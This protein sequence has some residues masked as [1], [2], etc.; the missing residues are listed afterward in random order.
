MSEFSNRSRV[1]IIANILLV[2][3]GGAKKT[4][5]MYRCNLSFRQLRTYLDFLLDRNL[6][7]SLKSRKGSGLFQTTD[8]GKAFLRAYRDLK[9]LLTT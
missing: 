6:L 9:V 3:S 8:K 5:I 1:E 7:V 4:E 2:A